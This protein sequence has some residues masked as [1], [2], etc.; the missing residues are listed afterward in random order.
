MYTR[1]EHAAFLDELGVPDD[2]LHSNG[3]RIPDRAQWG[4][5]MRRNDPIAFNLSYQENVREQEYRERNH[6]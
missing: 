2:D 4:Q 6:A 1:T 5:W 3:G